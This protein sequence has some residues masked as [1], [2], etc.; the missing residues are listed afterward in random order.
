MIFKGN[1]SV[2]S[3][4]MGGYESIDRVYQGKDLIFPKAKRIQAGDKIA[5]D[6]S[7]YFPI[8]DNDTLVWNFSI[9]SSEHNIDYIKSNVNSNASLSNGYR[10][11]ILI[12]PYIGD[13]F[14]AAVNGEYLNKSGLY[15][16]NDKNI[17]FDIWKGEGEVLIINKGVEKDSM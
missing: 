17:Y 2:K 13:Y 6:F 10:L 1:K 4:K 3:L 12:I 8:K 7:E 15:D 14:C 9:V 11:S 16:L 5:V